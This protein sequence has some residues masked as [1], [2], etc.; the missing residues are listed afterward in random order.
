[1]SKFKINYFND[2]LTNS[3]NLQFLK[4]V[5]DFFDVVLD[6]SLNLEA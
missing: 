3:T 5:I 6:A 4:G 1:M 2:S